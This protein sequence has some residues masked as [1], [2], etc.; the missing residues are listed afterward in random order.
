MPSSL[1]SRPVSSAAMNAIQFSDEALVPA[2]SGL[3]VPCSRDKAAHGIDSGCGTPSRRLPI[4]VSPAPSPLQCLPPELVVHIAMRSGFL[5]AIRLAA[6]CHRFFAILIGCR[7]PDAVGVPRF[8]YSSA[9]WQAYAHSSRDVVETTIGVQL[10]MEAW[11]RCV[12]G[13]YHATPEAALRAAATVKGLDHVDPVDDASTSRSAIASAAD[14]V[15]EASGAVNDRPEAHRTVVCHGLGMTTHAPAGASSQAVQ[16]LRRH[17][18]EQRADFLS[19]GEG[20]QTP[21]SVCLPA[22]LQET[23]T[24]VEIKPLRFGGGA[25][26]VVPGDDPQATGLMRL[27]IRPTGLVTWRFTPHQESLSCYDEDRWARIRAGRLAGP[28]IP[29]TQP[30]CLLPD[31]ACSACAVYASMQTLMRSPPLQHNIRV[32]AMLS[33][34]GLGSCPDADI[35]W[36]ADEGACPL[37]A[38]WQLY[39]PWGSARG[40]QRHV[41]MVIARTETGDA[42]IIPM[43]ISI[44]INQ[45]ALTPGQLKLYMR[46]TDPL[47]TPSRTV[48]GV[49]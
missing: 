13:L 12:S 49:S 41:R 35:Q 14:T 34:P 19:S 27:S 10:R 8:H 22:S 44:R 47:F 43:A 17:A 7:Q 37:L 4:P 46:L 38:E 16:A 42:T 23:E 2:S 9:A 25:A 6:T 32:G 48:Y 20:S 3:G 5:D 29:G 39:A 18:E 31:H 1:R 28:E 36:L 33:P 40:L 26:H 15:R 24:F 21:V 45:V 11:D 30:E